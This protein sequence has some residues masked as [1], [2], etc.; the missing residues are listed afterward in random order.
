MRHPEAGQ[1]VQ[2]SWGMREPDLF[3]EEKVVQE[4]RENVAWNA[5]MHL[6]RGI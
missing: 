4:T 2:R 3:E 6:W 1:Y 5:A